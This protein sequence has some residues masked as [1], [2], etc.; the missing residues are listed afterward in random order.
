M[1]KSIAIFI[2][3]SIVLASFAVFSGCEEDTSP[4]R[5]HIRANSNA[6]VDQAVKYIVRDAVVEYL[7]PSMNSARSKAEAYR[8]IQSRLSTIEKTANSVLEGCGFDYTANAYMSYEYFP[9]RDYGDVSYPSGNYDALIIELGSG[10]GNNW[11]CVAYP[12]LCFYGDS[13]EEFHYKSLIAELI[14]KLMG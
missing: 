7:T 11:W 14:A 2:I 3:L 10:T 12:P 4:I 9:D 1:K 5:I 8:I 6:D 13:S